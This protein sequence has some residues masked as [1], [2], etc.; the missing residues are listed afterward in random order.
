MEKFM[1]RQ[2]RSINEAKKTINNHELRSIAG[3][4]S[5]EGVATP[6]NNLFNFLSK[7]I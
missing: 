5:S 6:R 7:Y 1:S 4:E 2:L 3:S